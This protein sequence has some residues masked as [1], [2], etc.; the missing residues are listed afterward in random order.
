[1]AK[2]GVALQRWCCRRTP[3]KVVAA[4]GAVCLQGKTT[5]S[6]RLAIDPTLAVIPISGNRVVS[7]GSWNVAESASR[8]RR[9]P[10]RRHCARDARAKSAVPRH[11]PTTAT[12]LEATNI[13][14]SQ[15]QGDS[16]YGPSMLTVRFVVRG[17]IFGAWADRSTSN[18]CN[19]QTKWHRPITACNSWC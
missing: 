11:R 8:Q 2:V 13:I 9:L 10:F 17:W 19:R 5:S 7:I 6:L 1:M 3:Q 15:C 12:G 16:I 18:G 4:G 14:A